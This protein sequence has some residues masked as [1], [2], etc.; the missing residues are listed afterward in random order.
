[1]KERLRAESATCET[2]SLQRCA[3]LA[4]VG[5]KTR[6]AT[7]TKRQSFP[8]PVCTSVLDGAVVDPRDLRLLNALLRLAPGRRL[9]ETPNAVRQGHQIFLSRAH[10]QV[11]PWVYRT[12]GALAMPDMY[13]DDGGANGS[14]SFNDTAIIHLTKR[15]A[16]GVNVLIRTLM[17]EVSGAHI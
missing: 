13:F 16:A 1:M 7:L 3:P 6:T 11:Y 5:L 4:E 17:A 9:R 10:P 15:F 12:L 14:G 8:F 2:T